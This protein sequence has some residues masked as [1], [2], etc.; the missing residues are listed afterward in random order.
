MHTTQQRAHFKQTQKTQACQRKRQQQR[1]ARQNRERQEKRNLMFRL[2]TTIDHHFPI[3][4]QVQLLQ[5]SIVN[6]TH[7]T[8]RPM[9]HSIEAIFIGGVFVTLWRDSL[10][11]SFLVVHG[12]P[13]I[14]ERGVSPLVSHSE[15]G[16]S[17]RG[18][19]PGARHQG[20]HGGFPRSDT[21]RYGPGFPWFV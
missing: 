12:E 18:G 19:S 16:F 10:T 17:E 2:Q 7:P 20:L 4:L 1:K 11:P 3:V 6:K 5:I 15:S 13:R 14:P 8:C 21:A 9:K